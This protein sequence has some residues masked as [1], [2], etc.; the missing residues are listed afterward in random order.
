MSCIENIRFWGSY[1]KCNGSANF[2]DRTKWM[3]P[4]DLARLRVYNSIFFSFIFKNKFDKNSWTLRKFFL[5]KNNFRNLFQKKL[6]LNRY[7]KIELNTPFIPVQNEPS[8][9][10]VGPKLGEPGWSHYVLSARTHHFSG[11]RL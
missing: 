8:P 7:V 4:L 10:L 5:K 3:V 2:R 9:I 1:G 11:E 6:P